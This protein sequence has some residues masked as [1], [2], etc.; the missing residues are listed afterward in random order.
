MKTRKMLLFIA[1]ILVTAMFLSPFSP[2]AY[3]FLEGDVNDDNRID[4]IEAINALRVASG[5]QSATSTQILNVPGD[6]ATIQEAIDAAS[7]GDTISIAA[8]TITVT[9]R[10]LIHYKKNITVTG[11]DKAS[12]IVQA[13]T[14]DFRVFD[15]QRSNGVSFSNMTIQ[16]GDIGVYVDYSLV[17]FQNCNIQNNVELGIYARHNTRLFLMDSLVQNN[18]SGGR[19]SRN[20]CGWIW[21]SIIS[22]NSGYGLLFDRNAA[23]LIEDSQINDNGGDGVTASKASSVSLYDE[24]EV[25]NNALAGIS[26]SE[27]STVQIGDSQINDN[28]ENG[29]TA[30]QASSVSLFGECEVNNNAL[31]GIKINNNSTGSV[32]GTISGN[33]DGGGWE[34]GILVFGTSSFSTSAEISQTL[35]PG[36]HVSQNSFMYIEGT[37]HSNQSD[38]VYIN[39]DSSAY[40][41]G[42][43]SITNNSGYGVNYKC[44]F[45]FDIDPASIN[46][47]TVNP[48]D[49]DDPD[50][51]NAMGDMYCQ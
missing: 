17:N 25:N 10:I 26:I 18:G 21:Q 34:S 30:S 45:M 44:N 8:T 20:T 31:A 12:T 51:P 47:G 43:T 40:F 4:L 46:F 32:E 50:S 37:I 29:V 41:S 19:Y 1:G 49:P 3:G 15:I 33:G 27:N 13:G 16:N 38:G 2:N 42:E 35:G 11:V 22:S 48:E 23:F 28:G 14:S 6:F 5:A 39:S 24:C 9:E 7:E 36:I